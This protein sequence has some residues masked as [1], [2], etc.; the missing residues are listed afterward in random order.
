MN[1][2][3]SEQ[4][5]QSQT[6]TGLRGT[7]HQDAA[8]DQ[9]FAGGMKLTNFADSMMSQPKAQ[10]ALGQAMM[11]GGKYGLGESADTAVEK[12]G[13]FMFGKQSASGAS[14]G[15][16]SP[17]NMSGVIGSAVT[18][19]L[20]FL[21]PQIQQFQQAQFMAPQSMFGF[22]KS[23]ADYWNKA[24]GAQ[25]DSSSSGSSYGAGISWPTGST[26]GTGGG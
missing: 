9:A 22:A 25:S 7:V 23:A 20:P 2:S 26:G 11:P 8:A 16:M 15:M 21:I 3:Q 6:R 17:E 24:L 5:S 19:A 13:N 12:Y 10:L 1:Y 18:N 4:E 14:R